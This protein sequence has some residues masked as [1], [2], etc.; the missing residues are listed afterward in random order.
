MPVFADL[1]EVRGQS[2]VTDAYLVSLAAAND[3][4]LATLDEA[5]A[6]QK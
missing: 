1:S 5:L 3:A 6:A 2:Q 4:T